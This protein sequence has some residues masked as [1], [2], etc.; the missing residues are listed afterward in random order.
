M[1]KLYRLQR[2]LSI[3]ALSEIQQSLPHKELDYS[4][5]SRDSSSFRAFEASVRRTLQQCRTRDPC[6]SQ[7]ERLYARGGQH[8]MEM[9]LVLI[10]FVLHG[11]DGASR[12]YEERTPHSRLTIF[13]YGD[14]ARSNAAASR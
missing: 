9:Q 1:E 5:F 3:R 13:A 8:A 14:G 12:R 6:Q 4:F 11:N 2:A 7:M 10:E